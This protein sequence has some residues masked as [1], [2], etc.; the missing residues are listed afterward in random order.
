VQCINERPAFAPAVRALTQQQIPYVK[1]FHLQQPLG[2]LVRREPTFLEPVLNFML[3][4]Q[5]LVPARRLAETLAVPAP[6]REHFLKAIKGCEIRNRPRANESKAKPGVL[7]S[8]PLLDAS[9]HARTNREIGLS[10]LGSPKFD[11]A[12]DSTT[13]PTLPLEKIPEGQA[14]W[15]GVQRRPG[16][17]DLTIRHQ[18]PPVFQRPEAG[19]LVC[20]LPWEHKSVPSRWV[21]EINRKVDEL[22][23]PSEF[24]RKAFVSGGVDAERVHMLPNG[25]NDETFTPEGAATRPQGC[26]E[27]VFLF[28]GGAIRRK[29][30]D[31]LL[32]AY[33]DAFT[34][35]DDVTLVIKDLG[36]R[37]FYG[38]I[39]RLQDVQS[40]AQRPSS[41]HTLI[42]GDEMDDACLA[43][44]YRGA[45]VLVHPYRGE[46]FG[47]PMVEA[48]A[49]GKPIIA[50]GEGPAVEF[51]SPEHGYLLP[52]QE[53]SVPEPPPQ[54]GTFTGEWTW[55]EPDVAT[56]AHTMRHVYEHPEEAARRGQNAASAIR[57]RLT[58]KRVLPLYLERI[59]FLTSLEEIHPP[60]SSL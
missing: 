40:F 2:E 41:P 44:L 32:Q 7:L 56:L 13:W 38:G 49:C 10:L 45:N 24:V 55:F 21:E 6:Q 20:I 3:A 28:V 18:W 25:V 36:S 5:M 35:N 37:S 58:W 23:T 30:I 34:P 4:H 53:V 12:L 47:M 9:G 54:L 22:W 51:C 46:G 26:R 8:G 19:K 33:G 31:L 43:R 15:R 59:S 1:A 48:M 14:I 17:L 42:L 52:A 16:Y 60:D 50:T 39:T 57:A 11:A 27:F 29:G